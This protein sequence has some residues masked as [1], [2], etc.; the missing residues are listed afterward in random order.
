MEEKFCRYCG[1]EL[2]EGKKFCPNCGRASGPQPVV[3]DDGSVFF[4]NN[5]DAVWSYYL[6]VGSLLCIPF[7][8]VAAIWLGVRGIREARRNPQAKGAIH[9]WVGIILGSLSTIVLLLAAFMFILAIVDA[10]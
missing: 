8:G 6:G 2:V 5:R 1:S 7:L 10:R 9:A 4:P 3:V